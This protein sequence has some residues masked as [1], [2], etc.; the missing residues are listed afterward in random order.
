MNALVL[1]TNS[2]ILAENNNNNMKRFLLILIMII[3]LFNL[4]DGQTIS[5]KVFLQGAYNSGM[6]MDTTINNILPTIQPYTTDPWEYF[7]SESLSSLPDGMV[8]W[9]LLELRDPGNQTIIIGRRAA[10]LLNNGDVVDTNLST[11]VLFPNVSA[12]NYYLSVFHRN[13]LSVMSG[14]PISFPN[15]ITYDFSD[16]LN[17]P[18]YGGGASS[19]IELEPGVFGMISGD[20]NKDGTIKYSGPGNDRGLVLQY[21]VNA[22]GTNNITTTVNGY[23]DEDLNMDGIISYSGPANDP[24]LIVQDIVGMT[25]S[26]SITGTYNSTAPGPY[27]CG[28]SIYDSRDGNKY[29][30]TKI[31]SQCWMSQ[32]LAYLPSVSP[33]SSGSEYSPRYYVYGYQGGDV[34]AAKA[35]ANYNIYGVLYNWPAAMA[36][37]NGSNTNPSGVQGVCPDG[38]HLPSHAEWTQLTDHLGGQSVAGGDMKEA[39]TAHWKSPN[40]GATNLSGFRALP[41]GYRYWSTGV[42]SGLTVLTYFWTSFQSG[43]VFAYGRYMSYTTTLVSGIPYRLT[44]GFSVRCLKD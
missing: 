30:T 19:L 8:D 13:H 2:L 16:T 17:F 15:T 44:D 27:T 25:G 12:G 34:S 36:G 10:L 26:T 33:S 3:G 18:P 21:I 20:I 40:T 6:L 22:S 7:G 4:S 37:S 42:F 31:G 9:V 24:S 14:S 39:G 5:C 29:G 38:W 28:D 1:N 11:S 23:R 43:S 35:T 41:G 32:N